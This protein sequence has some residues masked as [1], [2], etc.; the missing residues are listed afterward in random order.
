MAFD[1][2]IKG[3]LVVDGTGAAPRSA[4]VG[5]A[6]GRIAEIGRLDGPAKRTINADGCVVTPGFIDHHTHYD[7]QVTFDPLC[8]FS[9]YNGVT[10]VVSGNCSLTLAPVREGDETALA[11]MLAKVE[12][13]PYDVL[14]GGVP[15]GWRTFGDYLDSLEGRLGINYGAMVGHS[16]VRRWVMGGD[17][18]EREA[19]GAEIEAIRIAVREALEDGAL[20]VSFD[21]NPRHVGMDGASCPRTSRP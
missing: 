17:S 18:Q 6:D 8:T 1:L 15:W 4:D 10:T 11:G 20:G 3:G 9:C 13:I 5:V 12:A 2:L 7:G 21:R 16:A 19:T 14:M